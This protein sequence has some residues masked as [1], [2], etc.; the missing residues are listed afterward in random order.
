MDPLFN[1]VIHRDDAA[2]RKRALAAMQQALAAADLAP[3]LSVVE[4]ITLYPQSAACAGRSDCHLTLADTTFSA[5]PGKS[6]ALRVH[7]HWPAVW[8][9]PC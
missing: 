8:S 2:F 5:E 4:A 3:A 6:H 7:W 9:M 1:P